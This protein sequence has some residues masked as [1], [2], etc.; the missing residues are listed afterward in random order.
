MEWVSG[1]MMGRKSDNELTRPEKSVEV[2]WESLLD[3][4]AP[5]DICCDDQFI[6]GKE[7]FLID[8]FLSKQ[9]C[10]R[11]ID[12]ANEAGFGKTDYPKH[13][14]GNLRLITVDKHLADR[15]Y[16]R[17]LQFLPQTVEEDES[18]WRISGLNECWR[19]AKYHQ[20]DRFGAHVDAF[21]Q[22]SMN[23]KTMF[24]VNVYLNGDGDF[25]GGTTRFYAEPNKRGDPR[26]EEARVIPS[27]GR[28]LVFRQPSSAH[29]RH[30]GEQVTGGVKY[31]LRSDVVYLRDRVELDQQEIEESGGNSVK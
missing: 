20:D 16:S 28:C 13:Y 25:M 30:D 29:Y 2:N 11:L 5:E 12:A 26:V 3:E 10:L 1:L 7:I 8:H 22:K 4:I 21:F 31:L 15:L 19:W 24:T 14:R 23:E 27:A 18:M 6:P 17:L 9:E